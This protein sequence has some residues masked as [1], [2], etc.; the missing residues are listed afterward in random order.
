VHRT[1]RHA[2]TA[3]LTIGTV[4]ATTAAGC[5]SSGPEQ[6]S[7]PATTQIQIQNPGSSQQ[8]TIVLDSEHP[9]DKR[10]TATMSVTCNFQVVNADSSLV[11]Q[12]RPLGGNNTDWDNVDDPKPS[13]ALPPFTLTYTVPCVTSLEYQASASID[14]LAEDGAPVNASETTIPRSYSASECA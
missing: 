2:I 12:G 11:I 6:G 10:L 3:V 5:S 4:L 1:R 9:V 8:C 14:A 13:S 7:A